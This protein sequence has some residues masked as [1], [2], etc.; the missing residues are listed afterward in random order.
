MT[1]ALVAIVRGDPP[2]ANLGLSNTHGLESHMKP[3]IKGYLAIC[4]LA[5]M[6]MTGSVHLDEINYGDS[7]KSCWGEQNSESP[8]FPR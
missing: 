2:G 5:E 8:M 1:N 7:S 3:F 4:S 6:N